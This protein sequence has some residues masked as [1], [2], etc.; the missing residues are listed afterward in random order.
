MYSECMV[1]EQLL[2]TVYKINSDNSISILVLENIQKRMWDD[3]K[4]KFIKKNHFL[5]KTDQCNREKKKTC[6]FIMIVLL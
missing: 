4:V 5:W 3:K 6:A 1:W 2:C